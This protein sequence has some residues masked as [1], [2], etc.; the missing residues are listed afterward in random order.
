VANEFET[1]RVD[2]V[3]DS[4]S[5]KRINV[6]FSSIAAF[7]IKKATVRL[8]VSPSW[9]SQRLIILEF[10]L[11]IQT[12]LSHGLATLSKQWWKNLVLRV[13]HKIVFLIWSKGK[14]LICPWWENSSLSHTKCHQPTHFNKPLRLEIKLRNIEF[15]IFPEVDKISRESV[16]LILSEW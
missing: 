9:L 12:G 5:L 4:L 3:C 6:V 10:I 15:S 7:H 14:N 8:F 2:S 13:Y 11:V 16:I 1:H